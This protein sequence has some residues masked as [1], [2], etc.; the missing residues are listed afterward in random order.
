MRIRRAIPSR[1]MKATTFQEK[2]ELVAKQ[3]IEYRLKGYTTQDIADKIGVNVRV[4]ERFCR[5]ELARMYDLED[6]NSER[7]LHIG[8]LET[9]LQ[10]RLELAVEGDNNAYNLALKTIETI[11]GLKGMSSK[12][13]MQ[14]VVEHTGTVTHT[15]GVQIEGQITNVHELGER[16]A[17]AIEKLNAATEKSHAVVEN[18]HKPKFN[19]VETLR[20]LPA[21][22]VGDIEAIEAQIVEAEIVEADTDG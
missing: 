7:K 5:Q 4:V 9:M 1:K 8:Q 19:L 13:T 12:R 20:S 3:I 17:R 22:Q 18:T 21:G 11:A 10:S 2:K 15:G 16:A 14:G 6:I